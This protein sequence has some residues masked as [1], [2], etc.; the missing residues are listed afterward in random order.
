MSL[1]FAPIAWG[2]AYVITYEEYKHH[3]DHEKATIYS[4]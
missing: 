1:I 4:L 3:F 2:L